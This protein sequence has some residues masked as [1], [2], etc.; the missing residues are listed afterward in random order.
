MNTDLATIQPQTILFTVT[1][2][3]IRSTTQGYLSLTSRDEAKAARQIVVKLRT[4]CD[5]EHKAAKEESLRECQRIDARKRELLSI[6]EPVETY[7][8]DVEDGYKK[9][10][11]KIQ[12]DKRAAIVEE[13]KQSLERIGWSAADFPV[14]DLAS[15]SDTEFTD[16][17]QRTAVAVG[18]K[19]VRDR[20]AREEREKLDAERAEL[21]AQRAA[22]DAAQSELRAKQSEIDRAERERLAAIAKTKEDERHAARL[23][24]LRPDYGRLIG[25]AEDLARLDVPTVS[26]AGEYARAQIVAALQLAYE[27]CG[28]VLDGM[29]R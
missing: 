20:K 15:F 18:D 16:F 10:E 29:V 17:R 19:K 23:K 11:E 26:P 25:V 21:D 2:K 1:E 22:L 24:E 7:L 6:I 3:T 12:A 28:R 4:T 13:R 5:K 14:G 8:N 27:T 9:A